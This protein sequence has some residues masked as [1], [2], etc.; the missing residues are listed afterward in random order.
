[1][2][3]LKYFLICLSAALLATACY[4]D[5]GNYDYTPISDIVIEDIADRYTLV[6]PLDETLEITPRIITSY[7]DNEL[8]YEW[9][10]IRNSEWDTISRARNLS[11]PI[12]ES[13]G[14]STILYRIKNRV[15][16]FF[17]HTTTS[18][19]V[20]SEFSRGFYILKET[21]NGDTDIDLLLDDN[22]LGT[23][24]LEQTQGAP[25]QGKPRSLGVMYN[26]QLINPDTHEKSLAHCIGIITYDKKVNILRASDMYLAFDHET[27]FYNEPDDIPYKFL[28]C[29][30]VNLYL[31]NNGVYSLSTRLSGSGY[32]G[33]PD[34]TVHASEYWAWM[35][36]SVGY[37]LWDAEANGLAFVN[38]NGV[39]S[40]LDDVVYGD[41]SGL[42][43]DCLFM[44]GYQNNAAYVLL[45]SKTTG[46]LSLYTFSGTY[47]SPPSFST[48]TTIPATSGLYNATIITSNEKERAAIYFVVDNKLYYYDISTGVEAAFAPDGIPADETITYVRHSHYTYGTP[49]FSYFVVGTYKDGQYNLYIYT[50]AGGLP[51]GEA[52]KRASAM[53]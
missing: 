35:V 24:I 1:M 44:A 53:V 45:K 40:R 3:N 2:K 29:S 31:S 46:L 4:K 10:R 16:G 18:L 30:L 15:N 9:I 33:F 37:L 36:G 50:M 32:L 21:A 27:L 51:A 48:V 6:L 49:T 28:E 26:R 12:G 20:Q 34:G 38:M 41:F 23:D 52:V 22:R 42:N 7:P 47:G 5:K 25:L 19:T 8:E 17:V 14:T 43:S 13:Q 39:T 11:Y